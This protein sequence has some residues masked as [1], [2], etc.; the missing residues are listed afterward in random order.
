MRTYLHSIHIVKLHMKM[1]RF[2]QTMQVIEDAVQ[3]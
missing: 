2:L 1:F 3:I